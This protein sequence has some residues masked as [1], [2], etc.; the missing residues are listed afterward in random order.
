[1]VGRVEWHDQKGTLVAL[2]KDSEITVS[3]LQSA[4]EKKRWLWWAGWY[5]ATVCS[6][7]H[8]VTHAVLCIQQ[9]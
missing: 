2:V 7:A 3:V 5:G 1:M 8:P 6:A 4:I 9:L